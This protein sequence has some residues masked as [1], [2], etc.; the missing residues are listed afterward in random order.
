MLTP[1]VVRTAAA[2]H[3][4]KTD[5]RASARDLS[6][7]VY[8]KAGIKITCVRRSGAPFARRTFRACGT[9]IRASPHRPSRCPPGGAVRPQCAAY[10]LNTAAADNG[11]SDSQRARARPAR[12]R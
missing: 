8:T 10:S 2:R 7:M 5:H 1:D 4:Y 3:S 9:G 12:P 6:V 11:G